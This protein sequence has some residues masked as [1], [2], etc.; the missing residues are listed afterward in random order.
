[1]SAKEVDIVAVWAID[2]LARSLQQLVGFLDDLRTCGVDLYVHTQG[3]NTTTPGGRAMYQMI[4]V[5]A[6]FEREMIR[7]RINAG[8]ARAKE[9]GTKLGA[10]R[11]PRDPEV[12]ELVKRGMSAPQ[13]RRL[14]GV[15]HS[16]IHRIKKE[17]RECT[18]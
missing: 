1:M 18:S 16:M 9:N 13:I 7:D 5:F 15:G 11:S 3:I 2:R 4:G 6:E 8:L 14:T 12:R 17:L 10:K